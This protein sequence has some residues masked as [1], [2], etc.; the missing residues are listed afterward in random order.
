M[1]SSSTLEPEQ[2][3]AP[4]IQEIVKETNLPVELIDDVVL[5]NVVGPGG[6]IARVSLL[7]AGLPVS[8]P[9]LRLIVNVVQ[10]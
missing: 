6:N 1:E 5:G 7:E 9:V 8:I 10:G 4:L 2:L 3:V